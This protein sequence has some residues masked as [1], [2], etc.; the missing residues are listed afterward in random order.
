MH[1]LVEQI[2]T[3][4]LGASVSAATTSAG[5]GTMWGW[6]PQDI[7]EVAALVGIALSC[8]MIYATVLKIKRERLELRDLASKEA[9][10]IAAAEWRK[11][12]GLPLMRGDDPLP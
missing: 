5:V 12:R 9:E 6:L 11:V 7:G 1:P 3:P 8:V 2:G 4:K 10:R